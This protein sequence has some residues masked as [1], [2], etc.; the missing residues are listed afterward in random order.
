MIGFRK[1]LIMF[2]STSN[3]SGYNELKKYDNYS[4][5]QKLYSFL[6]DELKDFY[7]SDRNAIYGFKDF[8]NKKHCWLVGKY[9]FKPYGLNWDEAMT[10]LQAIYADYP[11]LFFCDLYRTGGNPQEGFISPVVDPE[12]SR[13][14]FRRFY[15]EKVEEKIR[16][17]VKDL[18]TGMACRDAAKKVYDYMKENARYDNIMGDGVYV[19]YTDVASHSMLNFVREQSGVCQGFSK[20]YQAVMNH[21]TVPAVSVNVLT[22]NGKHS[23]NLVYFV[24]E[25][26]WIMVDT[27][28]GISTHSD[29]GFDMKKETYAR[30]KRNTDSEYHKYMPEY[31]DI[32]G[33]YLK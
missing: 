21:I 15:E 17:M 14:D 11:I 27:T 32:W 25:K 3:S 24:D 5:M 22:R 19:R 2:E 10:V 23:V 1:D 16:D 33:C 26:K 12:C 28:E 30:G 13:G 4:S 6:R 9:D 7:L 31:D 29:I 18:R 8:D 20:V